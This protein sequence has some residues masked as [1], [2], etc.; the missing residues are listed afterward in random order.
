M[1]EVPAWAWIVL[2]ASIALLLAIDIFSH[3]SDEPDSQRRAIFW[4]VV[5]VGAGLAVRHPALIPAD[6]AAL[7]RARRARVP[8][9]GLAGVLVFAPF[10]LIAGTFIHVPP[11]LSVAIIAAIIGV[12][13]VASLIARRR[14]S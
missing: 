8:R 10:K 1:T 4:T 11:L 14:R 5:W 6:R 12:S 2:G 9:Y 7:G 3:R 13:L